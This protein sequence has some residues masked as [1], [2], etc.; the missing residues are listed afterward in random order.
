[1]GREA[2]EAAQQRAYADRLKVIGIADQLHDA[3]AAARTGARDIQSAKSAALTAINDAEEAGFTVGEDFSVTSRQGGNAVA[4]AAQQARAQTFAA[5]IRMRV[6]ELI[7]AD[8]QAAGKVTTAASGLGAVGFADDE[9]VGQDGRK[10]PTIQ[11]VDHHTG[12]QPRP[13]QGQ[14]A[15]PRNPFVGDERFG[16]WE[17]VPPPPPYTGADPPPLKDQYRPFPPDTPAKTGGPTE[18]YVPGKSWIGDVDPPLV[19]HQ[20]QYK[21]RIAGQ[22]ATTTTRMVESNGVMREQRWVQNVYEAQHN[23]WWKVDGSIP[24]KGEGGWKEGSISIPTM[25]NFGTWDKIPVNQIATISAANPDVTFYLP[26]GCGGQFT[27]NNG[28]PVGG[29]SGK[30]ANPIPIMTAPR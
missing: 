7:A 22:E 11:L 29:F 12:E 2:A 13:R 24:V 20:E 10:D 30:P 25:P 19:Q 4:R 3:A 26:D 28:T 17:D 6:G 14:D 15:D 1:M 5:T 23:T 21:F 16:H 9:I 18:W 8:Q 27:Y